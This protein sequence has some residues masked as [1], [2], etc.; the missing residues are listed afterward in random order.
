MGWLCLLHLDDSSGSAQSPSQANTFYLF[1]YFYCKNRLYCARSLEI[2]AVM[3]IAG[4]DPRGRPLDMLSL[5]A[6]RLR[7]EAC[8]VLIEERRRGP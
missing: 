6:F 2:F 7:L 8:L 4:G 5:A 1:R 3:L